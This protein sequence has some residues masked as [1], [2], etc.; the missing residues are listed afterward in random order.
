MSHTHYLKSSLSIL[1]LAAS[2]GLATACATSPVLQTPA[3]AY[4]EPKATAASPAYPSYP[5]AQQTP[6]GAQIANPASVY[7]EAH[8]GKSQIRTAADGSQ[9]GACVFPDGSECEEWAYYRQQCAP[10]TPAAP[11]QPAGAQLTP[12]ALT[13]TQAQVVESARAALAAKLKV[14]GGKI[15]LMGVTAHDWPDACLGLA[16][17]GEVCATVITPGYQVALSSAGK[18][19]VYRTDTTGSQ[20]KEDTAG[21][22]VTPGGA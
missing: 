9:S 7:C 21:L 12:A 1:V 16:G 11:A 10:G 19:Y 13:A 14:D 2:I 8:D 5:A 17:P 15:D 3:S 4:P 22:I 18:Q 20:V 6:A